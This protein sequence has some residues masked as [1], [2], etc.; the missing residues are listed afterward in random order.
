MSNLP[1][2]NPISPLQ[3]YGSSTVDRSKTF[4]TTFSVLNTGGF[5]EVYSLSDLNYT[6][7]TGQT[8]NIEFTGNTIPIQFKKGSGSV[9]SPDV[10]T[11]N[12]DNISSGRRRLG[13][14]VYVYE[15]NKI[16][17]HTI[18]NYDNLWLSASTVSGPGGAT[19]VI[20]DFGTTVKNNT[21]A[22]Q[23]FINSWT[24]ST[25]E[26]V[27]GYTNLNATWRELKTGGSGETDT[28]VTGFSLNNHVISLTQN[29]EDQYSGFNISLSAYT[30]NTSLSGEYLPLSGGTV[31]G[32]TIF[33]SGLTASTISATTYNNL[34][35]DPDTYVTGFTF[36]QITY[37][38]SLN[39]NISNQFSAFTA[40]LAIL[41]SDVTI[42]GGTYNQNTG[43]ATFTNNSGGTFDVSGFTTGLTDTLVTAYTYN[44][45][46]FTIQNSNGSFLNAN[47]N[48][49]TG[50][51]V[52]GNFTTTGNTSLQSLTATTI[53]ATTY[54]NVNSVTGG[55]YS[56]G[57][58]TLSGTGNVNGNTIT[59]FPNS[60]P[61]L[62][63]SGGT[64]TGDTIFNSGLTANTLT[65]NTISATTIS[66]TTY[67]N[68]PNTLYTGNGNLSGNRIVG[69]GS[70]SL[71]FS[72]ATRPNAIFINSS[73]QVGINNGSPNVALDVSGNCQVANIILN[74][75]DNVFQVTQNNTNT[76]SS[77]YD[78][79]F[80]FR[81]QAVTLNSYSL[82]TFQQGPE[83]AGIARIGS[84]M[85]AYGGSNVNN[86]QGNLVFQVRNGASIGDSMVLQYDGN[87][88]IGT[89]TPTNR[90]HV[91]SNNDPVKFVGIQP[92]TDA[93]I[94][95]IDTTGVVH[96]YPL[97][98]ITGSSSTFTGGTVT[99]PTN[100]TNGL[101]ANT[102][103]ATTYDNL[104]NTLYTGNG[105][106]L[107]DRTVNLSSYT[108]NFSSSTAPNNLVLSGGNVGIG[109]STPQHPLHIVTTECSLR[110][111]NAD[112]GGAFVLSGNSGIPRFDIGSNVGDVFSFGVVASG[113]TAATYAARGKA[114]DSYIRASVSSNGLN[115]INAAGASLEDY[116]RFY[117]G[118]NAN[119][120][121][122]DLHIQGSGSTRGFIG[123]NVSSPTNRLHITASTDPVR[124]VGITANT[125]DTNLISIDGNG[126]L[127]SYPLSAVTGSSSSFTGGTVNG[128]TNFTNGLSSNTISAT[129][130]TAIE[131]QNLPSQSGTGISSF[132]YNQL[133]GILTITKNDTNTLTAG[134]FSYVSATTLSSANV[135]S[136][137]SNGGVAQ[138]STVNAVTGGSYS[139]GVI[140]LSGTG[141]VNGNTI[142][143]L[144]TPF[145]GGTV[146]GPTNFTNGLTANTISATTYYNLPT[147]IRTTGATYSN[148]TLTFTNNTG[149]TYSV[150]FNTLT[151]LT[152]NGNL[153][154]TG[155]TSL[156]GLTANTISAT[157]YSN[158]PNTIYTGDGSLTSNRIVSQPN[159]NLTFSGTS[160][161]SFIVLENFKQG[162]TS[163]IVPGIL[164]FAQG[165]YTNASGD[166]SHAEGN[167]S[168]TTGIY[169]HAEGSVTTS[170][171]EASHS[172]GRTTVAQGNYSHSEGIGQYSDGTSVEPSLGLSYLE[173]TI[174]NTLTFS[175][176]TITSV[177][178]NTIT[179]LGDGTYLPTPSSLVNLKFNNI[180]VNFCVYPVLELSSL[181]YDGGVNETTFTFSSTLEGIYGGITGCTNYSNGIGSHSEGLSTRANGKFSHSEGIGTYADGEGQ[182]VSGKYN[183]TG[184]T[185]SLFV[186]GNGSDDYNRSDIFN[187]NQTGA[188]LF[189]DFSATTIK[190]P[191]IS[192]TTY[193]N[194]PD[195]FVTGFTLSSNTITLTQN[196]TDGYSS[197]TISLSAYTGSSTTSGAFLPLSGGTV[198]GGTIFQSGL[199]ANTISATTYYNLPT[200]VF[201]TGGTYTSGNVIFTNNT[202]GTFTVT[203][204]AVGG[205]GGQIFYLNL[206]QSQN[207]NRLLSTTASTALEQSTGVTINNGVTSTIASFQ[208]QP[209]NITLLPGGIWSFYLHSYK[210]NN[211]ASFN[212]FVEVYKRTSGGTQ[213][214]LFTTDPAP[215]T[216]NS[217]NP[218]MQL[219]DGYFSGTPLSVSDSI[220]AVVRATNT[221]NQSHI[222][223][224]VS[225]GS[226]HYS[227]VV[228]TIPTQQ[229]L[230][231]DTLSGCSIIQ[232]IQTDVSNKLDKS[233]GTITGDLIINSGLTAPT[234]SATTYYGVNAV[235]G[236]TYNGTTGVITL[237][238]TGSVNGN[239]ITG[240]STGGGGGLTWNS[241]NTTQSMTADNGYI[242][243]AATLT[244]F[245]LPSTIA[246]GK[247]VEIAGNS[248]GLWQLNQNSG[249]QIRFGNQTTTTTSG[250]LSA[251]SQGDC[252]KLICVVADTSFIVTSS[253]GNIFFN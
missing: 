149:G 79:I 66:A 113:A 245:T 92:S 237:S 199:T 211:N 133:T 67:N 130:I 228:S 112:A 217:P 135:L 192:A 132:S 161:S 87:L 102:I 155:N 96:S 89:T 26:G 142:T 124:V 43:V 249:Q 201:V 117:A 78:A 28:F 239:Q 235:T 91:S 13:M 158:L 210:Q 39:Q 138:T 196:R 17:Q 14:L 5:M 106:I 51:T 56:N 47:F 31:T 154:V 84:R 7:P 185:S 194:Y 97:S 213:T 122:P 169:S 99:G 88:G 41:A 131:Y 82:L 77:S 68:L 231:C 32:D 171:G 11:L 83:G 200:D 203:G 145:T 114:T 65:A 198:T 38:L 36:D 163:N 120:G 165:S 70:S 52:N 241:S 223:T 189:G 109:T 118:K 60:F 182:H 29:R 143:G 188:L 144:T 69:L 236:G 195:T 134:T 221:G 127:H 49:V 116:I 137:T 12:S 103:S 173:F 179:V 190:S 160:S 167:S 27:S 140:V 162:D 150:L 207:G 119:Q 2:K 224:L 10:L 166:Y 73:G 22:G 227:Y 3:V 93:N 24:A 193:Y 98:G 148:N 248:S 6:I 35:I 178:S 174:P 233:G 90:L 240:F 209:L 40:N 72:G 19:V 129:T 214:L 147:D 176:N 232:T 54:L 244:T 208:S 247:T 61:Y 23:N 157:T 152:V 100:F 250:I 146:S 159:F 126:V 111:T 81:N 34:P 107:S 75:S 151:G 219:S 175:S 205:G 222:I 86:Y 218:S 63:L 183:L 225:E 181:S 121:D 108:L 37:K 62:P 21:V 64:V 226:Q 104:P 186:I 187:V 229:G 191:T 8:G 80:A 128:G 15:T 156:Q 57:V 251:T 25:I 74:S 252:V 76:S 172:E 45:N 18:D 197:F 139:N 105:T 20:S 153:T 125:S 42:T 46:T 136:V 33:Q 212:I 95:T 202:G 71:R 30:G 141:N 253:V 242:T 170:I 16:Y 101:T 48:T 246:F 216:T 53:S 94:L 243:T 1:Y 234:I 177:G 110:F 4:G 168:T 230:T 180:T 44:N 204:F 220:V 58:I 215:V 123:I 184:N 115:I 9:F 164:S 55:S 206:S 85:I 59:G 238:G 50:L